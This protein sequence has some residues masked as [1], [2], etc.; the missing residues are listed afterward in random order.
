MTRAERIERAATAILAGMLGGNKTISEND[1]KVTAIVDL[2][3]A[4]VS[5]AVVLLDEVDRVAPPPSRM[6]DGA[7]PQ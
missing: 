6:P 5:L 7:T 2:A 3:R 1:R 4:S